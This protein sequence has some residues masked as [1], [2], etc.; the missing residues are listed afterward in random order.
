MNQELLK[1]H[2]LVTQRN[3][4]ESQ[5]KA[6]RELICEKYCTVKVGDELE[7]NDHSH[8]GKTIVADTIGLRLDYKGL[9]FV[10]SGHVKKKNGDLSQFTGKSFITID[11]GYSQLVK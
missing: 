1:L 8:K 6:Q 9:Q 5:M 3:E 2:K 11:K 7:V 10:V 4:L